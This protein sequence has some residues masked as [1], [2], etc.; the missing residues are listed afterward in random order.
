MVSGVSLKG[1]DAALVLLQQTGVSY[2]PVALAITG[3]Y[4]RFGCID[5]IDEEENTQL[6]FD[7]FQRRLASGE[8]VVNA[9]YLSGY[10]FYP[11]EDVERLLG[12]FERNVNDLES[13]AVLDGRPIVF[14]LIC[15]AVWDAIA[16]VRAEANRKGPPTALFRGMFED[17]PLAQEIYARNL[18]PV[19]WQVRELSA[20]NG[21][22]TRRGIPWHPADDPSQHYTD[23]MRQYLA[24]ARQRFADSA[25]MLGALI[26]YQREVGDLFEDE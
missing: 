17:V 24:E 3:N 7:H 12:C 10:D 20:V 5:G 11:I 1:A 6:V 15:K 19:A 25:A 2:R 14:A 23:E 22:L 26:D 13:A 18:T 16:R 8:F 21:F 4:N 9:D